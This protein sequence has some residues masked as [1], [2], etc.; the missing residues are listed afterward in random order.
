[1]KKITSLILAAM[2]L[3]SLCVPFAYADAAVTFTAAAVTV[4]AGNIETF[5]QA[6]GSFIVPVAIT[7]SGAPS[8]NGVAAFTLTVGG[9]ATISSIAAGSAISD[10]DQFQV[11][12]D[13]KIVWVD[14]NEIT[15][16]NA[17]VAIV[18]V[19]VPHAVAANTSYTVTVTASE[20]PDDFLLIDVSNYTPT[21]VNGSVSFAVSGHSYN[22]V[23]TAPTC[24]A[25][26]YTTY[27]CPYCND[28]YTGDTVAAL[29]HN[30]SAWS[31]TTAASCT[32]A[33]VKTR[34]CS[35]CP[36]TETEA[37]PA[38]GH[39]FVN[40]SCSVCGA[41]DPSATSPCV[42]GSNVSGHAG[43]TVNVDFSVVNNPGVAGMNVL[44][45]YDKT[46][47]TA[48]KVRSGDF[49]T[50][51]KGNVTTGNKLVWADVENY[52]D[53]GLYATLPFTIGANVDPGVY[54]LTV[55]VYQA[56]DEDLVDV[57]SQF[58]SINA[59]IT[60][61]PAFIYGDVD[62]SGDIDLAD[63]V[64]L[65]QYIAN[66][67]ES[68]GTSTIDVGLGADCDASGDIDLSDA[69][70]LLQYIANYD[71]TTGTSSIVLGPQA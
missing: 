33:G 40:G 22:A 60:V 35:R 55:T 43:D 67:D 17:Q 27:T 62:D 57:T 32:T 21:T 18:N 45:E 24:T 4:N 46:S 11:G 31:V 69:V 8:N 64:M 39:T 38:N 13:N 44:V 36:A 23:V 5:R 54:T 61:L 10:P 19:A 42:V 41:P 50:I 12:P 28:S 29:G 48:G 30:W 71:E 52:D 59:T 58:E 20:E 63:A 65:L 25:A 51:T 66:Y 2:L 56:K 53:D 6:D 49:G 26:G 16:A 7:A 37:I 1:M 70:L 47:F 14:T 3:I 15:A 9:T 34:S 68:T